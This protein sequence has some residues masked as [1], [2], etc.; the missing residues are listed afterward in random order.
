MAANNNNQGQYMNSS[1]KNRGVTLVELLTVIVIIAILSSIA[2][3]TYR[4][5]VLRTQRTE[6]T[7]TLLRTQAAQEKFFAQN[8]AYA[9]DLAAAP[10]AGLGIPAVT[11]SGYYD[12]RVELL[13]EGSGYRI[14]ASP[15]A[16]GGQQDDDKCREFTVD[17]NGL[18][19]ARDGNGRDNTR[20]CWR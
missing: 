7:S 12:L 9:D 16:G 19:A 17:H 18:K 2:V 11:A 13:E 6:A 14:V 4:S 1:C 10:P 3:P 8:N 15:R 20:E 5:Y